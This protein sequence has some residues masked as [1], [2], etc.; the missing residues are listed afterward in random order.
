MG[1]GNDSLSMKS[2]RLSVYYDKWK[3]SNAQDRIKYETLFFKEFPSSFTDFE[4]LYGFKDE[5][6]GPLYYSSN[7]HVA[8][9]KKITSIS[10]T[11][12]YA[13]ILRIGIGGYWQADGVSYL[14]G[15]IRD[16][17]YRNIDLTVD[18]LKKY[19]SAEVLGFWKF[20]FDEPHPDK[21]ID[22]RL[23]NLAERNKDI[24]DLMIAAHKYVIDDWENDK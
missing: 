17:V 10:D 5:K 2:H 9:L 12:Y 8:F 21:N 16:A 19:S 4:K 23:D 20:Y 11:A 22:K 7:D 6:L 18:Q 3:S 13:K 1:I 14:Q 24:Y 15:V